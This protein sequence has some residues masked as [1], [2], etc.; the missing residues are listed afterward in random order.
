MTD[1]QRPVLSGGRS[2][3]FI[4]HRDI[5][6]GWCALVQRSTC[7]P[8]NTS[9]ALRRPLITVR[10]GSQTCLRRSQSSLNLPNTSFSALHSF[11][12]SLDAFKQNSILSYVGSASQSPKSSVFLSMEPNHSR[13]YFAKCVFFCSAIVLVII[14]KLLG[15]LP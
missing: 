8:M 4:L 15:L 5:F 2:L 14:C 7:L 13:I 1:I 10:V 6:S 3:Y 11:A 12:V 9:T